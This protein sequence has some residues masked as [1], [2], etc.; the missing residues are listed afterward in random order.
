MEV[1]GVRT[2]V[3]ESNE[4]IANAARE[5]PFLDAPVPFICECGNPGCRGIAHLPLGD[6]DAMHNEPDQ[7]L[8]G[9][10]HGFV[11]AAVVTAATFGL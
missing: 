8:V 10:A 5:A 3:R 1:E 6:F 4:K 9:E 7:F 2:L 11:P